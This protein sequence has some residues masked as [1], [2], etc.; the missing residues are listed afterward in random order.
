MLK[1]LVK[2]Q[3]AEI[4]R[5]YLYNAK[6][7]KAR[8]K[9]SI[10]LM[11]ILF[12]AIMIGLLGG[13]FTGVAWSMRVLIEMELDWF[14]FLIFGGI[15]IMLGA[16]GS[17]FNTF[18]GLYLA[19]DNDLLLAM[20]V[21]VGD[22]VA[23]RILTVYLMGL[24]YGV[25]VA[26][27]A[28]LVYMIV[29]GPTAANVIGCLVWIIIISVI[30]LVLSCLLGYVVA[31]LSTKLKHKNVTTVIISIVFIAA[32]YFFYFKA[33]S[34]LQNI[35]TNAV[36]YGESIKEH[37][38]PVYL[39]GSMP[40]GNFMA[41]GVGLLISIVLLAVTW[42]VLS[43]SFLKIV[44]S[45]GKTER[46]EYKEKTVKEKSVFGAMLGKE[47][48]RFTG[49]AN[50]MLNCGLGILILIAAGVVF[51]VKGSY[52]QSQLDMVFGEVADYMVVGLCGMICLLTSMNDMVAPSVALEG[53]NLW[54][55]RSL[56]VPTITILRAKLAVHLILTM[57]P[58]L[59][60]S[61]CAVIAFEL[62]MTGGIFVIVVPQIFIVMS[63]LF[64]L[65]MGLLNPNLKWTNEVYPI[66]Q[67]FSVM[68]ALFG[69]WIYSMGF[70]ALF[71]FKGYELGASACLLM[72]IAVSAVL[73]LILEIWLHKKAP[74]KFETLA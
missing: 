29:A 32:Y 49:S 62:T 18:S 48:A 69:G 37:A 14:Y 55:A 20:P 68:A 22:I 42:Y 17:V 4:F 30:V 67:S 60:C 47:F 66:K 72:F 73:I 74:Q 46:I 6:K 52:F 10:A 13:I 5:S 2:K 56:P 41:M 53:K 21:P 35:L 3:M 58:T 63:A 70:L 40:A 28:S 9:L 65:F 39:L 24:M 11:F 19:K 27:P 36:M 61:I 26:I 31:R 51:L 8:S 43:R 1:I 45:T 50:Y 16:F 34:V 12:G 33:S 23:S 15:S 38:Y 25:T 57:I 71:F 64:G 59:F 54:I 44:T 7:N